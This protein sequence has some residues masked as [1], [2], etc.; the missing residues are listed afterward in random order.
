MIVGGENGGR[1]LGGT[2]RQL[3]A[4]AVDPFV[5]QQLGTF[6]A[7]E[8]AADLRVLGELASGAVTPL[9]D[10]HHALEETAAAIRR[11]LEGRVTGNVVV[12]TR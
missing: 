6:I 4:A 8:N 12:T 2:D 3:R 7:G 11:V 5:R 9:I 10:S 1:W